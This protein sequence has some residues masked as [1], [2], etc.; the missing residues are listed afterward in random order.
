MAFSHTGAPE[1]RRVLGGSSLR[2]GNAM[3]A[4]S[5]TGAPWSVNAEVRDPKIETA[6]TRAREGRAVTAVP[7]LGPL[8][9]ERG[10]EGAERIADQRSLLGFFIRRNLNATAGARESGVLDFKSCRSPAAAAVAVLG[11]HDCLLC[12]ARRALTLLFVTFRASSLT[13]ES[14][15]HSLPNDLIRIACLLRARVSG[16]LQLNR[17]HLDEAPRLRNSSCS[18]AAAARRMS[19]SLA[20]GDGGVR[21]RRPN[22]VRNACSTCPRTA[23]VLHS[24][25]MLRSRAGSGRL[26]QTVGKIVER[27]RP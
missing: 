15:R 13:S 26:F 19:S 22:L 7:S 21:H 5:H 2:L 6:A 3:W 27:P 1:D 11:A 24:G 12:L 20:D 14:R 17:V 16:A 10:L 9:R 25:R 18:L 4:S 8:R 23:H